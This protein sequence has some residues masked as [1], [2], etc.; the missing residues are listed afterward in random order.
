MPTKRITE[1]KRLNSSVNGNPRYRVTF[2]DGSSAI[3][4]SDAMFCYAITNPEMRSDVIVTYTRAGRIA[5]I[6]PAKP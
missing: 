5:D 2:D 1:L 6:T 4:Q 3:T